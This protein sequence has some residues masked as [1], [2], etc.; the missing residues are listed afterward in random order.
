[1]VGL[2]GVL[3]RSAVLVASLPVSSAAFALCAMYDVGQELAVT[4]VF[5]GGRCML[6]LP[7]AGG[8]GG[9]QLAVELNINGD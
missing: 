1:M 4:N 5:L 2:T 8:E 6:A 7:R 9:G 3:A